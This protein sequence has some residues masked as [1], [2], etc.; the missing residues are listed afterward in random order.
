VALWAMRVAVLLL[1]L[2]V[3]HPVMQQVRSWPPG[4]GVRVALQLITPLGKG[5][6]Q[7]GALLLVL[8]GALACHRASLRGMALRGFAA[9][10]LSA[11]ADNAIKLLVPRTR[12]NAASAH[13]ASWWEGVTSGH[14][15]SFP[16]A[17]TATSFALA[18][19]IAAALTRGQWVPFVFA[20]LVAVARV[21]T[22]CHNPSDVYAGALLGVISARWLLERLRLRQA[23][24]A[25]DP[26]PSAP[27]AEELPA[28]ATRPPG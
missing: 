9:L 28:E 8:L 23:R 19:V 25:P 22:R 5:H 11:A 18:V 17:D 1:L 21:L 12:P 20:A 15:G 4:S 16:S 7:G 2:A 6:I 26:A 13:D 10:M 24:L 27:P 3:D 14:R